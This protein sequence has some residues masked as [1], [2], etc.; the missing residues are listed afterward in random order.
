MYTSGLVFSILSIISGII[1]F[2][3]PAF[4]KDLYMDKVSVYGSIFNLI[5]TFAIGTLGIIF[6]SKENIK[7]GVKIFITVSSVILLLT[8]SIISG[9]LIMITGILLIKNT[10]KNLNE[11]FKKCQF[12]LNTIKKEARI[13]QFC[14]KNAE[15]DYNSIGINI[16]NSLPI[17][18]NLGETW[19][20]KKCNEIN[21]II[22]SNL[23]PKCI[24]CGENN[25]IIW[26][27]KYTVINSIELKSIPDSNEV[28]LTSI[29][30]GKIIEFLKDANEE[31]KTKIVWY[32][33]KCDN[34]VGWCDSKKLEKYYE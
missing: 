31:A 8:G 7:Y 34:F 6:S 27:N 21:P 24:N 29:D 32:K 22:S 18:K 16:N 5:F 11:N 9:I 10:Q 2:F 20:C 19:I 23:T 30:K 14:R 3:V 17:N 26:K 25:E 1:W 28:T 12:C 4:A 33:I 13:C 15:N